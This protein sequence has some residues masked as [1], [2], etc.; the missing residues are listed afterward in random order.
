MADNLKTIKCPAC[1][2]EMAKVFVPSAGVN[3]DICRNCGGVYFDNREFVNFDEQHENIDEIVE[4]L[5]NTY[6]KPVDEN[7][8]RYCPVCGAKMVKNYSSIKKQ[9]Q[10]D[11]CYAC[12]GKFLD[13]NELER[14]RSEYKNEAERSADTIKVLYDTVGGELRA[15]DEENAHLK[16]SRSSLK[17][18]FDKM[19]YGR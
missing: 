19:V 18:L 16:A 3:V 10:V 1:Q 9:I 6:F 12:G 17:K 8:T 15:L 7:L 4:A 2:S 13:N 11:E 5:Q 14:I